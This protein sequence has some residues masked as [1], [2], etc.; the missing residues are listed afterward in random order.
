MPFRLCVLAIVLASWLFQAQTPATEDV[1]ICQVLQNPGSYDGKRVSFRGRLEFEFEGDHI[2]DSNC[3]L[4]PLHTGI[5][6]DYGGEGA[7]AFSADAA[8]I[9]AE[10]SPIVRDAQFDAF[11]AHTGAYRT[12]Q[13]NGQQCKSHKAC[14]YYEV[15]ATYTGKFFAGR[16][17]AGKVLPGFG[18]MGCCHLFV[19]E[20]ISDVVPK[21]SLVPSEETKFHCKA[22]SWQSGYSLLPT[23]SLSDHLAAN[24]QFLAE[25]LRGHG[26]EPLIQVMEQNL[27]WY[28]GMSGYLIWASPDLLTTYTVQLPV[29]PSHKKRKG[30]NDLPATSIPVNVTREHCEAMGN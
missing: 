12:L 15:V 24:K 4:P 30:Q 13:P 11:T 5:W 7:S 3:G 26:D 14:A 25:Q 22:E 29:V 21:R 18:H 10:T 2:D 6:W 17:G 23:P 1:D 16:T 27:S 8:R 9:Q 19:I 28:A 20:R